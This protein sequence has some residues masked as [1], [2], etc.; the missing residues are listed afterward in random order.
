MRDVLIALIPISIMAV[1]QFA[2]KS[3]FMI[4]LGISSAVVF[5]YLYQR[6]RD[7]KITI[8]DFSAAVTGLLVAL[9][10]P[11]TA[12]LWIIVL[13]SFVAIIIIKQLAGGIGKHHFLNCKIQ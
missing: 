8:K 12:P 7:K 4:L 5:E 10:Y 13:G 1:I 6:L 2:I 3:L 11:V 9:S